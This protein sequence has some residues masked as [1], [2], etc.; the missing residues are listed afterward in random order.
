[1]VVVAHEVQALG[2][3]EGQL[4]ALVRE[5]LALGWQVT[6]VARRCE[7]QGPGLHHVRV[8]GPRS[9][10]PLWYAWFAAVAGLALLRPRLRGAPVHTTGAVVPNRAR[11]STVHY[12]HAAARAAG[13]ADRASR[14]T[15]AHRLSGR[16]AHAMSL[17]GERWC[18]RPAR[19]AHL[20]AVSSGVGR[21]IAR[22]YPAAASTVSVIPN[23]V[24]R[25]RFRPRPQERAAV[26]DRLGLPADARVA[27]FVGGDW[28]RKGL[29]LAVDALAQAPGWLLLVV[30][31]G[32]E[33]RYRRAARAAGIAGRVRFAGVRGDVERVYAASDAFVL[34]TAYETFSLVT[35]E[36]AAAALPIVATRVS[37]IE[38]LLRDGENGFAVRRDAGS[39]AAALRR[40]D[41]AAVRARMGAAG[42][43]AVERLP[44]ARELAARYARLYDG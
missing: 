1:V 22:H 40:L 3:M 13:V 29:G 20:V 2:G 27:V 42:R 8:P 39:I 36:A 28:E 30:G 32:D 19:T 37:G 9:P 18:Y 15:L 17:A 43:A 11:V 23:A 16:V 12:C 21:E 38:D 6:V 35:Y 33:E 41:D 25:E 34:P 44:A 24:D 31:A 10:F 7:V 26:R 5:L 14:A 4:S